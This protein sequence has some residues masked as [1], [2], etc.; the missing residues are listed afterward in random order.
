MRIKINNDW[1]AGHPDYD[2]AV[3][4]SAEDAVWAPQRAGDWQAAATF[5]RVH[6]EDTGGASFTLSFS[7]ARAFETQRLAADFITRMMS[8]AGAHPWSGE[9]EIRFDT[10]G[11]GTVAVASAPLLPQ[12]TRRTANKIVSQTRYFGFGVGIRL[13]ILPV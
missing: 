8:R 10:E 4:S 5:E 13:R 1:I 11:G 2:P 6:Y 9:A 12:P 7:V 3:W